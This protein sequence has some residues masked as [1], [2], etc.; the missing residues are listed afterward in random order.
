MNAHSHEPGPTAAREM[1]RAGHDALPD[2]RGGHATRN[3]QGM[4]AP[5]DQV[6]ASF[7]A[8]NSQLS[9]SSNAS[10]FTTGNIGIV[11]WE[12]WPR[13]FRRCDR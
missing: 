1:A 8:P 2:S 6:A 5:M 10:R 7:I 4:A 9:S 13:T 3:R 12:P 11:C